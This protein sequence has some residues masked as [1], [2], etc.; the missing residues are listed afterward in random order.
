MASFWKENQLVQTKKKLKGELIVWRTKVYAKSS[1]LLI[2][3]FIL[4]FFIVNGGRP[5]GSK[6]NLKI[7]SAMWPQAFSQ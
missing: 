2:F 3:I 7:Q 4:F 1:R 6:R 5:K